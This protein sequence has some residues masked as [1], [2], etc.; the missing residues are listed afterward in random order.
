[1]N[2]QKIE[3]MNDEGRAV[4]A[5]AP[6]IISASRATDIPAFYFEWFIDRWK[7]GY[8]RWRNPF[9]GVSS[10]VSF[11][12]TRAVV[13]WTKNAESVLSN[14]DFLKNSIRNFYFQY[15]LNDYDDQHIEVRIPKLHKRISTFINLSKQLGRE[16]V[17]WRFDPLLLTNKISVD[18]LLKRIE[19]V[20]NEISSY[21]N[22]LVFSFAD[23]GVYKKVGNNLRRN[24]IAYLEWD[25]LKMKEFAAGVS[26]MNS[27]WRLQLATCAEPINLKSFGIA[28]NS[29]VDGDLMQR[30]FSDDVPLMNFLR[31]NSAL[32][33]FGGPDDISKFKKDPGQRAACGCIVSKDIGEYDTCPHECLY[34]YA[35]TSREKALGMFQRHQ[36]KPS[37]DN[38]TGH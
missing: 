33:L 19:G 15:T 5:S 2:W 10:Y 37:S 11:K 38:I 3:I 34:C 21:T 26:E 23:I 25:V 1:M 35:N 29:C 13:F 30:L 22:K 12:H 6:V 8:I 20:G 28:H 31:A 7:R 24:D 4:S 9:N 17:I 27:K 32:D 18:S 14:M 36:K 16:R